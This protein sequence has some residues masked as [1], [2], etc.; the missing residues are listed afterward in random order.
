MKKVKARELEKKIKECVDVS[1]Q[2]QVIITRRWQASRRDGWS[3]WKGLG[4]SSVSDV[5]KL[6]EVYRGEEEGAD[7]V[8]E[9][10]ARAT[11]E[12]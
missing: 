7:D 8:D 10:A 9:G 11:K 4:R 3:R 5:V 6:L 2:D 1:Q 12:T